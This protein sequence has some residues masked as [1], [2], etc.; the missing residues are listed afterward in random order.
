M[1]LVPHAKGVEEAFFIG[2]SHDLRGMIGSIADELAAVNKTTC[3]NFWSQN[4]SNQLKPREVC[5]Q[6]TGFFLRR[7]PRNFEN[8]TLVARRREHF[9]GFLAIFLVALLPPE[10]M[11]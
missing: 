1:N 11:F 3:Q 9:Q 2:Y 4:N 8:V 5:F 10:K 7:Q 6:N